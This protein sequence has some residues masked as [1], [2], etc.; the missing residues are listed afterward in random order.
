MKST[1]FID[2]KTI[3]LFTMNIFWMFVIFYFS[4]QPAQESSQMSGFVKDCIDK[5]VSLLF[6]GNMPGIFTE[7]KQLIEHL[8]RKL[9]HVTE[10]LILGLLTGASL[11]KLTPKK[12]A[13]IALAVCVIYASSD[14]FHQIFVNGRGP[15][16]TDVLLDSAAS[17][18][19]VCIIKFRKAHVRN[20][21]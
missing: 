7:N 20:S 17:A 15:S 5:V 18:V 8:V 1:H 10:Y 21:L 14:E 4:A 2:K 16:V 3:L 6:N 9:G 13:L 12:A 19:G 11:R